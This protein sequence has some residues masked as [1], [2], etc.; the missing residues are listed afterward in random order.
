MMFEE[1][2]LEQV[3]QTLIDSIDAKTLASSTRYFKE[4]EAAK[5]RGV[6]GA[7]VHKIAKEGFQQIKEYPKETI[8]ELCEELWKS[9][10]LEEAV[11]ACK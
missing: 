4:G 7:E 6:K 5:V 2:I 9:G 1:I 10:Y 3:R 8:F 11:V